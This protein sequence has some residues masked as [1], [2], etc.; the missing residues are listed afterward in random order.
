MQAHPCHDRWSLRGKRGQPVQAPHRSGQR[1]L[2]VPFSSAHTNQAIHLDH[3]FI[4][5]KIFW[6]KRFP[7]AWAINHCLLSSA[8]PSCICTEDLVPLELSFVAL[9]ALSKHP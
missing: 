5:V 8:F 7:T 9:S 6:P 2:I 1:E 3:H 4:V